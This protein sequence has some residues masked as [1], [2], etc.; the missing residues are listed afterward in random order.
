MPAVRFSR[1]RYEASSREIEMHMNSQKQKP[2][3]AIPRFRNLS[4][5]DFQSQYVKRGLPV[6]LQGK[7]K[8]WKCVKDWSMT[9]LRENYGSDEVSIFDP[10]A[11]S[12]SEVRYDVE[13]TDLSAVLDAIESGDNSKYSRFNRLLY[14]HPELVHDF[15][16]EWLQHTR[17]SW[18]SGKTYQVFIGGKGTRTSLHCAGEHNLF[19]QVE[20]RK[21]WHLIEPSADIWLDPPITRT[22]YFYSMF[23]PASVDYDRYPGMEYAQVWECSLEP[24][25]VLFNPPFWWHQVTNITPSIGVGF[26]WFDLLENIKINAVGTAMTLMSTNP[27]I[28]TATKHRTDFAAI[29]KQMQPEK[30]AP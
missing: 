9:W 13:V 5:H 29:F 12:S 21:H 14:D 8:D 23:D 1:S 18:S 3:K 27:T 28:W 30:T 11:S 22:P 26:R 7:A 16:W 19:T 17:S 10:L 6:I 4:D 2:V 25:D 15:D 24:G 20:G